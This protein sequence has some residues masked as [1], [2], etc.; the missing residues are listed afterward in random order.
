V[1]AFAQRCC[2]KD[3]KWRGRSLKVYGSLTKGLMKRAL[4]KETPC[5]CPATD[6]AKQG[7]GPLFRMALGR[8]PPRPFPA[9]DA[10]A[11]RTGGRGARFSHVDSGNHATG[12]P[13]TAASPKQVLLCKAL[14]IEYASHVPTELENAI[15]RPCSHRE[16]RARDRHHRSAL[17]RFY[18]R[19]HEEKL[20]FGCSITRLSS[21]RP[22]P[23]IKMWAK[24]KK[25]L[26]SQA[27]PHSETASG[28]VA[29][30]SKALP[31]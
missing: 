29:E 2:G 18:K 23:V 22:G 11:A 21:R 1:S 20:E 28:E 7:Q 19:H 30:W 6:R 31:C 3:T 25:P 16:S 8:F 5:N 14:Y 24:N 13:A 9:G 26:Q 12:F 10:A 17:H 4:S 27:L 15:C